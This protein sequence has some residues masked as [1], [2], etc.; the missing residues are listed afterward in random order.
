MISRRARVG[1]AAAILIL[2]RLTKAWIEQT[3]SVWDIRVVIPGV[4]NIVHTQNRGAA[5]GFLNQSDGWWRMAILIG[6]SSLVSIFVAVQLWRFPKGGWPEKNSAAFGLSLMMG[7]ALGNLMD[8]IMRGTVTDF[9]QVFIGSY[10]W[11]S[12]NVADSAICVGA[13]LLLVAAWQQKPVV[14]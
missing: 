4:F 8:R 13:G 7:G 2:D 11:P 12:F 10:E 9:L 3:F 5:F 6:I 1:I 14:A